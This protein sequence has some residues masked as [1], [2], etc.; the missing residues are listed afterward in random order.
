M[1]LLQV[2]PFASDE[3]LG[4]LEQNVASLPAVSDLMSMGMSLEAMVAALLRGIGVDEAS[5]S[6]I[7]PKYGPCDEDAL[8]V[9]VSLHVR[10][11][12]DVHRKHVSKARCGISI[13]IPGSAN[14]HTW[15][16]QSSYLAAPRALMPCPC[17]APQPLRV[18][19]QRSCEA[20]LGCEGRC[21]HSASRA[22]LW[23]SFL[24][25]S[26]GD[27]AQS[28]CCDLCCSQ[29]LPV[30]S[31]VGPHWEERTF[32]GTTM[33]AAPWA[34]P[35]W[36][37]FK[38]C[39]V[40]RRCLLQFRMKRAVAALGEESVEELLETQG[41][42]EVTCNFCNDTYQFTREDLDAMKQNDAA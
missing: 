23:G 2:L 11:A 14:H 7:E 13:V 19:L 34:L 36:P 3:T 42:V 8:K 27:F 40:E 31:A 28:V 20:V 16:R 33:L 17:K 21:L 32:A 1:G 4:Q 25:G 35:H 24:R 39:H 22:Q 6:E 37:V 10:H 5:M 12:A 41:N 26:V 18:L 29:T 38:D 15:Q 9:R 30:T